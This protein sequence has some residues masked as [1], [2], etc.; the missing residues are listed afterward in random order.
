MIV[1][2]VDS[3]GNEYEVTFNHDPLLFEEEDPSQS[4]WHYITIEGIVDA[5]G[6]D[7]DFDEED[8]Y[9][10]KLSLW[11]EYKDEL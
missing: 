8:L 9:E 3:S 2:Y 5:E 1:T 7:V 11:H 10:L 4:P 6:N